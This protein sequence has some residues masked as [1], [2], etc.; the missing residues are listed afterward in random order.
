MYRTEFTSQP[1]KVQIR[2]HPGRPTALARVWT[3]LF[4]LPGPEP[5]LVSLACA[6]GRYL[7]GPGRLRGFEMNKS[8][9]SAYQFFKASM[10]GAWP[11]AFWGR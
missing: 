7:S 1:W 11:S 2:I 6:R 4:W 8:G 3:N 10:G 5:H 9:F